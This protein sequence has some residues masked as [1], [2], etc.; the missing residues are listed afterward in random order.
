MRT[1]NAVISHTVMNRSKVAALMYSFLVLV[2]T[3][4]SVIKAFKKNS[5]L[6]GQ[7]TTCFPLTVCWTSEATQPPTCCTPSPGYAPSP[8]QVGGVAALLHYLPYVRKW[9]QKIWTMLT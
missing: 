5:N 4:Y 9:P 2:V 3:F 8:G 1:V 6:P 7:G